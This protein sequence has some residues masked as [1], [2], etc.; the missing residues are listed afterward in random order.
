MPTTLQCIFR[1]IDPAALNS[2]YQGLFTVW[3]CN[4]CES[5][6]AKLAIYRYFRECSRA[7]GA[8][9]YH[10]V[11][12]YIKSSETT[13]GT[14]TIDPDRN[15]G[16]QNYTRSNAVGTGWDGITDDD[17]KTYT[18]SN[19]QIF[20]DGVPLTFDATNKATLANIKDVPG[21]LSGA[22]VAPDM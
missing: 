10:D 11:G 22:R 4:C 9:P 7:L 3:S 13:G 14:L 19:N 8:S 20:Y 1:C 18:V 5:F 17:K 21:Y 16:T 12:A 6:N 2:S 15:P